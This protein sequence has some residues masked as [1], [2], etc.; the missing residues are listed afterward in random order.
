MTSSCD[1]TA[2]WAV[3]NLRQTRD[4]NRGITNGS[5]IEKTYSSENLP[6]AFAEAASHRQVTPL[7]LSKDRKRIPKRG[8]SV[9]RQSPNARLEVS[10]AA[11]D[12][13]ASLL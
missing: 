1:R 4:T 2:P 10:N 5:I 12:G 3:I 7:C 6:P 11:L 8:N 13:G 9:R